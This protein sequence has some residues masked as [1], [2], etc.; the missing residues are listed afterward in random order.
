MARPDPDLAEE[1]ALFSWGATLVGGVDEVGRGAWA[2]PVTVGIVTIRPGHPAA[3]EGIRDSKL[4]SK[5]RRRLL[6]PAI[7]AWAVESATGDATPAE[8]DA[9]GM[10]AAVA[11]AASR[12]IE[13]LREPPDAVIV[14]GPLDLLDGRSEQLLALVED[15]RWRAQPP[16]VVSVVKADQ[17]CLS[18]AAASIVAKVGRDSAMAQLASSF[19]AYDFEGNVGYPSPSHQRALFGYGLTAIH[20]R[21]WSYV[22]SLRW[23]GADR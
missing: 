6:A 11:L 19:P 4:V 22:E 23:E 15:H 10:R 2:G 9:L 20:R 8:C 1:E 18:V 12:A 14:D 5:A 13:S 3:P 16:R 7:D 21:S 17:R